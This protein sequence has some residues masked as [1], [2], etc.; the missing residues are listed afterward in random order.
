MPQDLEVAAREREK[1]RC[2][3][4]GQIED[5]RATY[6]IPP[7]FLEDEDLRP[8]VRTLTEFVVYCDLLIL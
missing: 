1:N 8:G 6:V 2:G 3:I 7:S 4:T 5:L